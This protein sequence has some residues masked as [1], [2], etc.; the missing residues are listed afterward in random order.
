MVNAKTVTSEV[1]GV[2]ALQVPGWN[3]WLLE[4]VTDRTRARIEERGLTME[5]LAKRSTESILVLSPDGTPLLFLGLIPFT[6]L[7]GEAYIWM[8]P[9]RAFGLR[10]LRDMRKMFEVYA[11]KFTRLTAQV[12]NCELQEERFLR[13]FSFK[14]IYEKDGTTVYE[15][16]R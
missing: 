4:F 6:L 12:F 2:T 15:R 5:L 7:G 11:E 16:K 13:F 10:H 9:F 14:A 3:P 8:V 1:G